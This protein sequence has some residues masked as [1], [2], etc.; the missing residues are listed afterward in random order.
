MSRALFCWRSVQTLIEMR[1][2]AVTANT[3]NDL[4]RLRANATS[5][6]SD[7]DAMLAVTIEDN[8]WLKGRLRL[9]TDNKEQIARHCETAKSDED[10]VNELGESFNMDH[11]E[12]TIS[13]LQRVGIYRSDLPDELTNNI[14]QQ[15]LN[16]TKAIL[17]DGIAKA[18]LLDDVDF[19]K[20]LQKFASEAS[21]C[22]SLD[23]EIDE[24]FNTIA[25]LMDSVSTTSA[26][27]TAC[28][29]LDAF[30]IAT[31]AEM[32]MEALQRLGEYAD[33]HPSLRLDDSDMSYFTMASEVAT[34]NCSS[35]FADYVGGPSPP[36]LHLFSQ[37]LVVW[38][39]K[40]SDERAILDLWSH[41]FAL[42]R[43]IH[44]FEALGP[45]TFGSRCS[46][47][48]RW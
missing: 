48:P 43:C 1:F 35:V 46:R 13:L 36:Y 25:K 14:F 39:P 37:K 40:A 10:L 41:A 24:A 18:S 16:S 2:L 34:G 23:S 6:C 3:M 42:R 11:I 27:K 44:A 30:C 9:L 7:V 21:M 45:D 38:I 29:L 5:S 19:F 17:N 22:F 12:A 31:G 28:K 8:T 15:C 4:L 47:S 33:A 32:H 26:K 20:A